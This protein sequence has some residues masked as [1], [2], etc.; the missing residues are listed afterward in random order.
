VTAPTGVIEVGGLVRTFGRMLALDQVGFRVAPGE[1][2]GFLGPNGAGKSTTIRILLG[3]YRRD[4]G[5]VRV[6]DLDPTHDGPAIHRRTGYLPGELALYS[7]LTARQHLDRLARARGLRRTAYRDELVERFGVVLDRPVRGLSKGSRQKIGIVAAFMHQPELL[8]LDEP[9]SGLDPL[10]QDEFAQLVR[11]TA[12][13]GRTVFL[14]SH[15]LP[16]VQTLAHRVAIIR[17]GR[18]VATD[19]VE[20]LRDAAPRTVEF[21]FRHPVD[22]APFA[23][24]DGVRVTGADGDRLAL[25]VTGGVGPVLRLAADQDPIGLTARSADLDE[26][27]LSYYR[28]TPSRAHQNPL[29]RKEKRNAH[30]ADD[31]H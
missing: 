24:I 26:L 4:S 1:V 3:L 14:S 16:E 11:E 9:T 28:D 31:D 27:F 13:D 21:R 29:V 18:I 23:A 15:D 19:T 10:L 6:F 30:G 2:F 20:H 8:V 7:R 17:K 12:A 25:S 22:P 5:R